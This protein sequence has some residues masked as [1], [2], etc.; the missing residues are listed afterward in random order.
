MHLNVLLSPDDPPYRN[1]IIGIML[2]RAVYGCLFMGA[3]IS[4]YRLNLNNVIIA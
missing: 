1:R 4:S 2:T 3:E